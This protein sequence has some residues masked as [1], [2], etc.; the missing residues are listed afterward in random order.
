MVIVVVEQ[1]FAQATTPLPDERKVKKDI[2]L[3]A[4]IMDG[5]NNEMINLIA[6]YFL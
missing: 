2:D 5:R 1:I 6:K 4:C 3:L